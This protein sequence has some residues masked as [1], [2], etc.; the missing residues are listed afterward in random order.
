M[1]PRGIG[2]QLDAIDR[3]QVRLYLCCGG[4]GPSNLSAFDDLAHLSRT[5]RHFS[6]I[7]HLITS[8]SRRLESL[9]AVPH[10]SA[11]F[12]G[13]GFPLQTWLDDHAAAV[14]PTD[15]LALAPFSFPI[16]TLLTFVY[17]SIAACSLHLDPTQLRDRLHGAIGHS[18]GLVAA[19]AIA[20]AGSG[21]ASFYQAADIALRLSFWIG[22]ESHVAAPVSSLSAQEI[23]DC[24]DH[25]EGTSSYLLNVAGMAPKQLACFVQELNETQRVGDGLAVRIALVNGHNKCVL[26][27]TPQGL[28]RACLA[29]RTRKAPAALD[30][31]RVPFTRRQPVVNVQFLPVSAPYHSALLESVESSAMSAVSDV[32]LSAEDLLIPTYHSRDGHNLQNHGSEDLLRVLVRAITV[33][34]VDWPATCRGMDR[35]THVLAVG[36][37]AAGSLVQEIMDGTGVTIIPVSGRSLSSGRQ[38]VG[39]GGI[40]SPAAVHWGQKY[41][42]RLRTDPLQK[43]SHIETRMTR[44]LGM[45]P[46]MVSGMTPTTVSPDFVSAV[47]QA[48]FHIEFACGGYHQRAS[49]EGALRRLAANIPAHRSITCNVIY[50]SPKTLSWQIELLRVLV[51]EG[52]P[53]DGLTVGAGIPMPEVAQDWIESLGLCHI[54]FKPGS[55]DAIDRVL[56]IARQHPTFPVGLQWTGGRAGGHHSGEDFHQPMLERYRSIRECDNIVL[57]A[58]SGFGGANDTWPYL[59]GSWS[60]SLGFAAMP[61]DGVL[62]G[63]R[64]MVALEAK[65]SLAAKQVIVQ[66]PGIE[67]DSIG[68]WA[69]SEQ[70]PIGGVISVNSEMG[71]PMHVLA[72]RGMCLWQEFDRRFFSIRDSQKR[73]STMRHYRDEVIARLNEHYARPWFAKTAAGQFVEIEDLTYR[74]VLCRLCQ[75]MY[76]SHQSRWIHPSYLI[77]VHDFLRLVHERFGSWFPPTDHPEEMQAALL[78]T[79]P[80]Q[81]S[82]MLYSEDV[83][84]LLALFRRRGQK[85][86]PFIPRLDSEFETWFKKDSL[87]QS[88][89]VDA[90]PEQDPQRVCIIHGPVAARH[91]TASNEAAGLILGRIRDAHIEM[92]CG[93]RSRDDEDEEVA[94]LGMPHKDACA[95][96][97]INWSPNGPSCR[98]YLVGPALPSTGTLVERLVGDAAWGRAALVNKYMVCG[99]SRIENP[100]RKAFYPDVGGVVDVQYSEDSPSKITLQ[101]APRG[102]DEPEKPQAVLELTFHESGKVKVVLL[103][104]QVPGSSGTRPALEL[105]MDLI[106]GPENYFLHISREDYLDRIR[107]LYAELWMDGPHQN[108][109]S[110]GLNSEFVG[111]QVTITADAVNA[112][113]GVIRQTGPGQCYAW[114]AQGPVVPLDYAVV[115]AWAVLTKP[116]LLP[117]LDGAPVQ[118]LHQ[119]VSMRLLPRVRPLHVG[120]VVTTSS[121]I[122]ERTITA[123]GQLIEVTADVRRNT[124][125]VVLI[126]CTFV[127][128]HRPQNVSRQQFRSVEEPDMVMH[129]STPVQ[130]QVLVSRKWLLLDEPTPELL[131]RSLVFSL[132]SQ[133]AYDESGAPILLQVSGTVSLLS[134]NA[135]SSSPVGAQVGRLYLEEEQ[136]RVNPVLDFLNR[137]A[138]PRIRRQVLQSPGWPGDRAT[139]FT[140]PSQSAAYA[141]VSHDTNPIHYCQLFSRFSGRGQPVVHGMH[142]SAT[143]RR[144]LEWMVGDTLRSRFRGWKA[145]F[146]ALVRAG[147]RLRME[148][149]HLAMEE[150]LMVVQVKV[151]D[152]A[153]GH[154]VFR[155]EATIAQ[156]PTAYV[157]SGQGSQEKGMGMALYG[158]HPAAQAVWDRAELHFASQYG[159]APISQYSFWYR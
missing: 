66:A 118:L 20:R 127:L 134:D 129:L 55:V 35:P 2:E 30:Q 145:E 140:A 123:A 72:T 47:M 5:Y 142:L 95:L 86:V 17:Y 12:G 104:S 65:T 159:E 7:Q 11:F 4:Q 106:G 117:A 59:T 45:P 76:V 114:D 107:R 84:L 116:V 40:S 75:L 23:K 42:P 57:V 1:H 48:G 105:A 3:G 154:Q 64:M 8:A 77:L 158:A 34:H 31:S 53:I 147:D 151:S 39:L 156:E 54:W 73:V 120:D 133:T 28:R 146:A 67:D 149:Q 94:R 96:P 87:W 132:K 50:A 124:E 88:E 122:T 111:R 102:R 143:V 33:D 32:R 78:T 24:L 58:G 37:G 121:C 6:P 126:R 60:Q 135:T 144:I 49:M 101:S 69:R 44:L 98:Y 36:P 137:H 148:V 38:S 61:L 16:N 99:S 81:A 103:A 19:A 63:S 90:V 157:F 52:L 136:C 119:S 85:P 109:S 112:F 14:P 21:W 131:G 18:Q 91:S 25:G 26:A 92:L 9:A 93:Q 41:R 68:S 27:G 110:A 51:Q 46:V 115:I 125:P 15:E 10:H 71:Q 74:Q 108:P 128:Q 70:E 82:C 138:A 13:R 43:V 22:L 150:G 141:C 139:S 80:T 79:Y 100:I 62:L 153:N 113:L 130:L 29:L 97:G 83:S 155:A 56:T 152:Q 89:D